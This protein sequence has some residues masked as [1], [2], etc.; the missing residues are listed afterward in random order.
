M[1]I[2]LPK[3][4]TNVQLNNEKS[5]NNTN[6]VTHKLSTSTITKE[7][8]IKAFPHKKNAVTDDIV[9]IINTAQT[10]PEF[11]G[12]TLLQSAI[13][14]EKVMLQNRVGIKDYL[15]ALRFC[16]YLI[17]MDDNITEAYKKVFAERDFVANRMNAVSG[18]NEY[19]ELTSAASRYRRSKLVV[20]ILTVSQVPLHLMFGGMQYEAVGV[21]YETM[22]TARQDRDRINAAKE[23]L[24]AT[25]APENMKI[26]LDVG[27]K[28]TSAVAQLNEQ[29][30]AFAV[31]SLNHLQHGNTD[32]GK[33]GAMKAKDDTIDVDVE[34]ED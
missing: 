27:V 31:H 18:S 15:S 8:I 6:T 32:L 33:L 16:A 5:I 1:A 20:D 17:S 4:K 13:T 30:A 2:P 24:A 21:L 26:E 7:D 12:E 28:E 19:N 11:Q 22:K 9:S 23:L 34:V 29:L 25:K 3:K 14:Y 10:E